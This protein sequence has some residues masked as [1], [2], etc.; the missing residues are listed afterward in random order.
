MV[1]R[2]AGGLGMSSSILNTS[3]KVKERRVTEKCNAY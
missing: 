1:I 2:E 3:I